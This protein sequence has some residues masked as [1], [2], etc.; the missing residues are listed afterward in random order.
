MMNNKEIIKSL[1]DKGY[2][3]KEAIDLL[4]C[5]MIRYQIRVVKEDCYEAQTEENK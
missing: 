2:T 1:T 4:N 5:D 3:F